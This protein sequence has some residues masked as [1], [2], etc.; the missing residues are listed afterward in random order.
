MKTFSLLDLGR[1]SKITASTVMGPAA[2][3]DSALLR[4][5]I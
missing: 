3:R 5:Y 1:A 2:E 4:D